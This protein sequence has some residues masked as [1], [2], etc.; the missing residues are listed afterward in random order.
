M[1]ELLV[2]VFVPLHISKNNDSFCQNRL[3]LALS[4]F[5]LQAV[6]DSVWRI[7][8]HSAHHL[9][10]SMHTTQTGRWLLPQSGKGMAL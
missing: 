8:D 10:F 4:M 6:L 5:T 2:V 3:C 1:V 7:V 9:N